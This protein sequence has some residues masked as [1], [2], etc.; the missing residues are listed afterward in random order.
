MTQLG[1]KPLP[2]HTG[3]RLLSAL[4]AFFIFV[5]LASRNSSTIL[6]KRDFDFFISR[7]EHIE[8]MP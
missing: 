1:A 4:A 5:M 2:G 3:E 8:A 7:I 6:P